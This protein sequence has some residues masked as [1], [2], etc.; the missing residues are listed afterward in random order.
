MEKIIP[1]SIIEKETIWVAKMEGYRKTGTYDE[2]SHL[3]EEESCRDFDIAAQQPEHLLPF[4]DKYF[5]WSEKNGFITIQDFYKQHYL[6]EVIGTLDVKKLS[7]DELNHIFDEFLNRDEA[8][9]QMATYL[10]DTDVK[11]I[12]MFED[13]MYAYNNGSEEFKAGIDKACEILLWKNLQE[14]AEEILEGCHK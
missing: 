13:L 14:I 12:D 9:E 11:T 1:F 4:Y 6:P 10:L 7:R 5:A 2:I 3:A 8:G